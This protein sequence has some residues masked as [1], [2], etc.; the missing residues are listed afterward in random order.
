MELGQDL[1]ANV[2]VA[3]GIPEGLAF[4]VAG[5]NATF[6]HEQESLGRLFGIYH[7]ALPLEG[8]WGWCLPFPPLPLLTWCPALAA[9]FQCVLVTNLVHTI[10]PG[11]TTQPSA[12]TAL[13]GRLER[14]RTERRA[15]S[16]S[17]A[18]ATAVRTS[19]LPRSALLR[20]AG[21]ASLPPRI[22]SPAPPPR[23]C[24]QGQL[25]P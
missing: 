20:E 23:V 18:R 7:V 16:L 14:G 3:H 19:R 8:T 11:L 24:N 2:S 17:G 21:P 9:S 15:Q 1:L 5:L 25:S 13:R 12:L 6:S 10:Q 22:S 4:E